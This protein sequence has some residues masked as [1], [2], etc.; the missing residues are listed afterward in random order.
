[1]TIQNKFDLM[2]FATRTAARVCPSC[3][4]K[5]NAYTPDDGMAKMVPGDFTVCFYCEAALQFTDEIGSMKLLTTEELDALSKEHRDLI[6]KAL[7]TIWHIK[8]DAH[9]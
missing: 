6:A 1:M 2:A 3:G 7:V 9:E 8:G 4:Q 5:L